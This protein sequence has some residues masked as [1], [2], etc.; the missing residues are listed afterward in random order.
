MFQ[1]DRIMLRRALAL[2]AALLLGVAAR[3][4]DASALLQAAYEGDAARVAQLV[5][6]GAQVNQANVFGA[7]PLSEAARRGDAG[8]LRILLEAGANPDSPNAEGQTAL[9]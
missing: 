6:A 1:S 7:T 5:K 9:M 8:V 2:T 4:D 3:A